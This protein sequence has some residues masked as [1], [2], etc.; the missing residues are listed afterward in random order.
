MGTL[1]SETVET[2]I[3]IEDTE[4]S[5][6]ALHHLKVHTLQNKGILQSESKQ[7]A[8]VAKGVGTLVASLSAEDLCS[9]GLFLRAVKAFSTSPTEQFHFV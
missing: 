9:E 1:T 4:G 6:G 3:G 2:K 5:D 8:P 7:K